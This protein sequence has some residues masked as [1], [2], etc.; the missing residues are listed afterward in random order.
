MMIKKVA[1][2]ILLVLVSL[3]SN[4]GVQDS[5]GVTK[6]NNKLHIQYLISPGETIYGISTKYGISLSDLFEINPELENGLKVGQVINIPYNPS[7]MAKPPKAAPADAQVYKVQPGDTYYGIA[8]KYNTTVEQLLKLNNMD[9]KAGQEIVVG[10]NNTTT[11]TTP[12]TPT[13]T[14]PTTTTPTTPTTTTTVTTTTPKTTEPAT[15]PAIKTDQPVLVSTS[16]YAPPFNDL[17]TPYTYDSSRKQILVVPFDPYLYFSDADDE[18]A[19]KSNMQRTKVREVFRR[20]LNTLL[21][22]PGYETIHLLGGKNNDSLTDL[23]KIYSSV[24]YNYQASINNPNSIESQNAQASAATATAPSKKGGNW[25]KNSVG[26]IT[27]SNNDV[28]TQYSTPADNG[29][30]FGVAVRNPDFFK[31]FNEKY[32]ID[33]Y[34]FINQFEVKTNYQ[35]CLDR[36][37]LNYERTFIVHYS[38]F[39]ANGKQIAGDK[40]KVHYNSNNCYV[41]QIVSDNVPKMAQKILNQLPPPN[42][43]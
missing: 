35:N 29:K 22:A 40:F 32:S 1:L 19:G 16:T 34:I 23:N 43:K 33:Y 39:D 41:Y 2:P 36:A 4:A 12:T 24:S 21:I 6:L 13:T 5:I 18:I 10:Y 37:A 11:A 15:T 42:G 26:T 20:R 7:A 3:I 38:I 25:I 28:P 9:L 8:K 31:Y 27:G 30:Y 14:N 17:G